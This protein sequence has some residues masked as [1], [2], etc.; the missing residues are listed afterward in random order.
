MRTETLY[1]L[2][3]SFI[4]CI[5]TDWGARLPGGSLHVVG[6][7]VCLE[8]GCRA[9]AQVSAERSVCCCWNPTVCLTS[10]ASMEVK[11]AA[12]NALPE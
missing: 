10:T 4:I 8:G 12:S 2:S 11:E 3:C 5:Q 1:K 6:K 9:H 7:H